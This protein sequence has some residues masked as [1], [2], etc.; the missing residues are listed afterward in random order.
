MDAKDKL[1]KNIRKKITTTMIGALDS[2][3]YEFGQYWGI[4]QVE[5]I[6]DE[7]GRFVDWDLSKLTDKQKAI[8]Y[9]WLRV[10]EE[11]LDRGNAQIGAMNKDLNSYNI[12]EERYHIKFINRRD[13]GRN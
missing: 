13:N 1:K 2:F 6:Y 5:C 3:E 12:T 11:V 8:F 9:R 10:R 4:D 7:E